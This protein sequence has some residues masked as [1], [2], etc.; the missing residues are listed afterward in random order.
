MIDSANVLYFNILPWY[1]T[2]VESYILYLG[3]LMII[4]KKEKE[5]LMECPI[6]FTELRSICVGFLCQDNGCEN[7]KLVLFAL[8]GC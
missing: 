8:L 7:I 3:C 5:L 2:T 4:S 6:T 1:M